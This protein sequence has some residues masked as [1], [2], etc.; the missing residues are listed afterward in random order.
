VSIAAAIIL[1]ASL[2]GGAAHAQG[3]VPGKT[4]SG[5]L[6]YP[7]VDN[8]DFR[9]GTIEC[10][11]RIGYDPAPMLPPKE[12]QGFLTF[13][14]AGGEGGGLSI[15]YAAQPKQATPQWFCSVSPKPVVYGFGFTPAVMK[16]GEWHHIAFSWKGQDAW[17]Y[18]DGKEVA[19]VRQNAQ[20]HE[21]FG[22]VREKPIFIGDKWGRHALMVIDDFRVSRV[23]RKPAELGFH[24]ALKP[25][26]F[27]TILD[28]FDA[29]FTPDGKKTTR[30]AVIW[31]G[32]GG[33]PTAECRFVDGKFGKA[34]AFYKE[35]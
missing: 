17:A 4:P 28:T 26:A 6:T 7:A 16:P 29:E 14:T 8:L 11:I 9:E 21:V 13:L 18:Y 33:C 3:V 19:T 30:P 15:G 12:Y 22:A 25:D 20:I 35:P 24:G 34:L 10:W 23:A 5:T 32:D 2:A 27:T 31:N 1:A